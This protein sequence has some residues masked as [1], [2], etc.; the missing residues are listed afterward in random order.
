MENKKAYNQKIYGYDEELWYRVIKNGDK[1]GDRSISRLMPFLEEARVGKR[2]LDLG[3]GAGRISNRLALRGYDLVGIDLS[4]HL[5]QDAVATAKELGIS[6]KTRYVVGNYTKFEGFGSEKFDA[7]ICINAPSWKT[8]L[9]ITGFFSKLSE[10]MQ[11]HA[12]LIIQ[13]TLREA[14]LQALFSC[15]SVQNWFSFEENLLSLHSWR[16]NAETGVVSN[17]KQFYE[18][19][20]D[21]SLKF[22]SKVDGESTLRSIRDYTDGLKQAGWMVTK[23]ERPS[24][25]L[26]NLQEYND[27]WLVNTATIVAK[28]SN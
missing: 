11:P 25:D 6:D 18:K 10:M 3:C 8:P 12:L 4:P 21:G 27:P 14:F 19:A 9:E 20:D 24:I 28:L 5:I 26:L 1:S 17:Y 23:V 22:I 15:P 2:I 13:D 7:A 16:Y